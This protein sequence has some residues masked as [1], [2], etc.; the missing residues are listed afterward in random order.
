M[1][2]INTHEDSTII[3]P[4]VSKDC[5]RRSAS[6]GVISSPAGMDR[7][8]ERTITENQNQPEQAAIHVI[9]RKTAAE[10][11]QETHNSDLQR[12][13]LYDNHVSSPS[14]VESVQKLFE[15]CIQS[16]TGPL[17]EAIVAFIAAEMIVL[18][19][20]HPGW[21]L[22]QNGLEGIYFAHDNS[23]K[24]TLRYRSSV[25]LESIPEDK[26]NKKLAF[27][28]V[29]T[30]ALLLLGIGP[31]DECKIDLG[32][33]KSHICDNRYILQGL[34]WAAAFGALE[35]G[36][37]DTAISM[38][39]ND[40]NFIKSAA[41]LDAMDGMRCSF[42][43]ESQPLDTTPTKLGYGDCN[44]A[45]SMLDNKEMFV[46][47]AAFLD[48]LEGKSKIVHKGAK[49]VDMTPTKLFGTAH[50]ED[51]DFSKKTLEA[52]LERAQDLVKLYETVLLLPETAT[53]SVSCN[54]ETSG[55]FDLQKGSVVKQEMGTFAT[56]QNPAKYGRLLITI[57]SDDESECEV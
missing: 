16:Q 9:Q 25:I 2:N 33:L 30:V 53:T 56:R 47:S 29:E 1:A 27:M 45:I 24:W 15:D 22:C 8:T 5:S 11:V 31:N 23:G 14:K 7:Q 20:T 48:A 35:H 18:T 28:I 52:E 51:F 40:E 17:P 3:T 13:V 38:L 21:I 10:L 55:E 34:A 42:P 49:P 50:E 43:K 4:F 46:N 37:R 26:C 19:T 39:D 57:D 41:F 6:G 44:K 36:H 12:V 54:S 32:M